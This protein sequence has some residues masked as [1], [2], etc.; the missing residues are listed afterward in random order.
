MLAQM[1]PKFFREWIKTVDKYSR[2]AELADA[3]NSESDEK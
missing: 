2:A 3:L 1:V